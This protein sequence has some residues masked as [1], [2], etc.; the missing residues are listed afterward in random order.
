[1]KR[2]IECIHDGAESSGPKAP[3]NENGTGP[4]GSAAGIR[5]LARRWLRR[6]R[7]HVAPSTPKV[8]GRDRPGSGAL[9]SQF[10]HLK[11]ACNESDISQSIVSLPRSDLP[12]VRQLEACTCFDLT[13]QD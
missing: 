9:Q 7:Q 10:I 8:R 1:M 3:G 2:F 6:G 4:I 12:F 13:F 5:A 11:E